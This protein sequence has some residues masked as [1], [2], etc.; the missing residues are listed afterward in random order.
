MSD[1]EIR[2]LEIL[3]N[4][5]YLTQREISD[6]AN[7]SLGSV[8]ATLKNLINQDLLILKKDQSGLMY[9][10]T[11]KAIN[12]LEEYI[13]EFEDKKINIHYE[14]KKEIKQAVILAAGMPKDFEHPMGLLEVEGTTLIERAIEL[15]LNNGIQKIVIVTGY[16]SEL[17]NE[18]INEKKLYNVKN[19]KYK[20]TGTM[21]SLSLA[22]DYI[23]DDFILVENDMIYEERAIGDVLKNSNRDCIL[24]TNESGSGDEAFVEIR[25]GY[26]YKMSKDMHQFNRIDG[27]MIGISKISYEVYQK[28][29]EEYKFNRNP[30]LNYEYMLMDIGRN[31][32]IGY[33][34]IDDL[35]WAEIDNREHYER[36][37]RNVYPRMKRKEFEIKVE[38][39]KNIIVGAIGINRNDISG[40]DP[41]GGMINKSF[42][43][44]IKDDEYVLRVPG[45]GAEDMIDRCNEN[46]NSKLA[47]K[48]G[49]GSEVI[50]FDEDTGIKMSRFIE[51]AETLNPTTAKKEENM[52]LVAGVLRKLHK[53]DLKL[54]NDFEVFKLIKHYEYML[55]KYRGKSFDDYNI[56]RNK[57]MELEKLLFSLDCKFKP[58]HN[59]TVPENFI[60]SGEDR[61][62]LIDWEYSGMNDPMWD[63]A[64]HS[65]ECNFSESDEELFMNIYFDGIV[66]EKYKT[67]VLINKILQDFLWSLWSNIKEAKGY[68]FGDYGINRYNRA[69]SNLQRLFKE[70]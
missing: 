39:L 30:Y 24:V 15:L 9:I 56:V 44:V 62:Y 57:I 41:I 50:Y 58:C 35:V 20:W 34:K 12:V 16:K 54:N 48:V 45:L 52:E 60:K 23:E 3:N 11:P 2:I 49:V 21:Y 38:N 31:Y 14:D 18:I 4:Q 5:N 53:S 61:I 6:R 28:M 40:I 7:L 55:D 22:K 70:Y 36:V 46:I 37:I 67:R 42:K 51:N 32:N 59:D 17:F 68:N 47:Y 64:S 69:K 33:I 27:E 25:N 65:I 19:D 26:L 10:L 1:K 66:E 63:I 43:I 29:L 13:K 8:N